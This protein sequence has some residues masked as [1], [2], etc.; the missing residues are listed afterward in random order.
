MKTKRIRRNG[1][2]KSAAPQAQ[3][4]ASKIQPLNYPEPGE[5]KIVRLR[6]CPVDNPRFTRPGRVAAFWRKQVV[7]SPWFPDS[8]ECCCVFLLNTRRQLLGYQLIAL[9]SLDSVNVHPREV[10]RL[11]ILAAAAAIIVAHNH[12]SGDPSPSENDLRVT[13]TLFRS[14][15]LLEIELLDHVIIGGEGRCRRGY[16]SLRELGY[17]CEKRKGAA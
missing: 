4:E 17:L 14:G 5:F 2:P 15:Q 8:V 9:G 10:F 7:R 3:C 1:R 11:A 16:A 12:P 13:R 6:E